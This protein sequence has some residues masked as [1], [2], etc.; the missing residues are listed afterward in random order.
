MQKTADLAF[1]IGFRATFLETAGKK[2]FTQQ[3]LL[4]RGVH[5]PPSKKWTSS[6]GMQVAS[7]Y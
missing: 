2:H 7:E 1:V 3:A 4:V 5:G 6:A